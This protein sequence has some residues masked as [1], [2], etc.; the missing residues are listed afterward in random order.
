MTRSFEPIGKE[1]EILEHIAMH[2]PCSQYAL[3]RKWSSRTVWKQVHRL[4]RERM[5]TREKHG[6]ES[7]DGGF[8]ELVKRS[9]VPTSKQLMKAAMQKFPNGRTAKFFNWMLTVKPV[10]RQAIIKSF[11]DW[12]QIVDEMLVKN[13]V[14]PVDHFKFEIATNQARQITYD[15]VDPWRA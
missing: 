13:T 5:I 14:P 10:T 9:T 8:F 2:G 3:R 15:R 6:Y 4:E 7:T 12:C 1:L 11:R